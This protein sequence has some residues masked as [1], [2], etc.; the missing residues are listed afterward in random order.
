MAVIK[1]SQISGS[2]AGAESASYAL[3]AS[4]ALN[5]SGTGFPFSGSAVITGSLVVT[6]GITGSMYITNLS[7]GSYTQSFNNQST[8]TVQHNLNSAY[9]VVQ[10]YDA[11]EEQM[12]PQ[13]VDLT[14][15]NTTTI[16]FPIPMSGTAI[17]VVGSPLVGG[18]G[19]HTNSSGSNVDNLGGASVR[20]IYS[21][22]NVVTYTAGSG[23]SVDFLGGSTT[24][25]SRALPQSF[26]DSSI[27]YTA[28]VVHFRVV[29][30]FASGG[31]N[32]TNF[33]GFLSIGDHILSG[34]N[35]GTQVLS[36]TTNKP[37]EILGEL[38]ITSGSAYTC[39]SIGWCD[40][41]GDLKRTPLS[42][43]TIS[44]SF[45]D[46]TPGDLKFVVSGSTNRSLSSYY[47]YVQVY[48]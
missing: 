15:A 39:Y 1:G 48:N 38:I 35:I 45:V 42:N 40:Q 17:V 31:G 43:T 20:T 6:G 44:G 12:L 37:F 25:G 46:I 36:F 24:W 11:N 23:V 8:W 9:V 32:D 14:D 7:S 26:F 22:D 5:S 29:G 13:T 2:V 33:A 30:K 27:N 28:K 41:T 16:T 3:T 18:G 10:T 4:Y 21:R 47:G 34:S 19:G